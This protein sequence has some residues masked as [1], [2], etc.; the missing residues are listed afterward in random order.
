MPEEFSVGQT[1]MTQELLIA[2]VT[3]RVLQSGLRSDTAPQAVEALATSVVKDLWPSPVKS[4]ILVLAT[5][6]VQE[7]LRR[8][9]EASSSLTPS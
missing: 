6:E 1:V 8:Y 5:R 2:Q 9:D 4:F 3:Q 7:A